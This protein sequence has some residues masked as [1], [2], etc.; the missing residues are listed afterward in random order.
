M[1]ISFFADHFALLVLLLRERKCCQF[2][3]CYH[4]IEKKNLFEYLLIQ[5][6]IFHFLLEI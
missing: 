4:Q 3:E 1:A 6:Q 2:H 5:G